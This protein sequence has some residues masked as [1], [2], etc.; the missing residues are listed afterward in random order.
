MPRYDGR[1]EDAIIP[2]VDAMRVKLA[3][4]FHKGRWEDITIEKGLELL[5]RE[6]TELKE[7]IAGGNM[8]EVLMESADV[9]NVAMIV[10]NVAMSRAVRGHGS[11][12]TGGRGASPGPR[13]ARVPLYPADVA[14]HQEERTEAATCRPESTS[15]AEDDATRAAQ[16]AMALV[17]AAQN[18]IF[19]GLSELPLSNDE[20]AWLTLQVDGLIKLQCRGK[21]W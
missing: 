14:D 13:E 16:E 15:L 8:V 12:T 18:K 10:Y 5:N 17:S 2:F 11:L 1:H 21:T 19:Q 20:K 6:A 7:A 3:A 4:N 9:A